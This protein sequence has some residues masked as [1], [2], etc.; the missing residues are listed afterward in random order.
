MVTSLSIRAGLFI[1]EGFGRL[2]ALK[3]GNF[4]LGS[5]IEIPNHPEGG[6]QY[7]LRENDLNEEVETEKERERK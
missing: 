1:P 4:Y 7:I 3:K 6:E 2:Q 5:K